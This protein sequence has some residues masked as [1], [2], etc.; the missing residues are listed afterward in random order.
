[1]EEETYEY[2]I[3]ISIVILC[4]LLYYYRNR[5]NIAFCIPSTTINRENPSKE[6]ELIT[7]LKTISNYKNKPNIYIGYDDDDPIYSLKENRDKI[8]PELNIQ[9]YEQ[10]VDKGDVVSIWNNLSKIAVNDGNNYIMVIGD[11]ISYPTN[12]EWINKCSNSLSDNNMIGISAGDSGNPELP[13]TQF[14]VTDKHINL[15]GYVF[16]PKLKNYY[17]DNYL[18]ELYPNKYINY[19]PEIKLTNMGGRP[20]Y[21]PKNDSKLYKQLLI[22]D[23][24]KLNKIIYLYYH[25]KELEKIVIGHGKLYI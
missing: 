17:C 10:H 6:L 9:W 11:D 20:R 25:P 13:M 8:Y 23:K 7:S 1:M 22:Q 24:P 19:F 15:Y 18:G 16:N 21:I 12:E 14:M 3:P 2:F 5:T 4:I